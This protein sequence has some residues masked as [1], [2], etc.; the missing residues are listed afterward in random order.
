MTDDATV[1][2]VLVCVPAVPWMYTAACIAMIGLD[3]PPGSRWRFETGATAIAGKRNALVDTLLAHPDFTHAFFLDSDMTPPADT[4]T[5]L[6]AHGKEI[7]GALY[8]VRVPPFEAAAAWLKP[9]GRQLD[10]DRRAEPDQG[11]QRVDLVGT[12]ALLVHRSVFARFPRPWF[13]SPSSSPGEG[14]DADFCHKAARAGCEL[15]CDTDL[16]VGHT[17]VVPV[18]RTLHAVGRQLWEATR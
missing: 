6:L 2:R 13:E 5:R 16:V 12:G 18:E 4:L 7:V 15:W 14:E 1:P 17:A 8:F 10:L 9:V 11:L 3:L